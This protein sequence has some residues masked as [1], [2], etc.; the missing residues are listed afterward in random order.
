MGNIV[1]LHGKWGDEYWDN[2]SP[3]TYANILQERIL[4]RM[5]DGEDM[6][7]ARSAL[8]E[9][10]DKPRLFLMSRRRYEYEGISEEV[11]R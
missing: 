4:E 1:V 9:G 8:A 10:G 2:P 5:Y 7:K 3:E 11:T 6:A